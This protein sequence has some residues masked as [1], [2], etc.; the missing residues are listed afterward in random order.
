MEQKN[1]SEQKNLES[2]QVNPD[3]QKVVAQPVIDLQQQQLNEVK[4]LTHSL[5]Q[6]VQSMQEQSARNA[7]FDDTL[8]DLKATARAMMITSNQNYAIPNVQEKDCGCNDEPCDCV[9]SHCCCFDIK[10]TYVRVLDMQIEPVDSN[11]QPWGEM[12]IKMFAYLDNGIGALI[13]NMFDSMRLKKLINQPGIKVNVGTIIGTVC[14]PKGTKKEIRIQ[15][16]ALE[17]ERGLIEQTAGRDEEGS[18]FAIMNLD[19]CCSS[20]TTAS[21]ELSFTGGGQGGGTIEI[22]FAAIKKC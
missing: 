14:I 5:M 16:D 8:S 9:D 2:V 17:E 7:K 19:C 6:S 10:M 22:G 11:I 1:Q 18:G 15:V 13:P 4:E 20:S 12:E 3:L 21:I